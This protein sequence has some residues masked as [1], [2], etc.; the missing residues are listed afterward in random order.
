MLPIY[1]K[2]LHFKQHC[3]NGMVHLYDVFTF[4]NDISSE[5][6]DATKEVLKFFLM[7]VDRVDLV[8]DKATLSNALSDEKPTANFDSYQC[9]QPSFSGG[10]VSPSEGHGGLN[11]LGGL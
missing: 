7:F 4:I 11:E 2:H 10:E 1:F 9:V 8:G 5:S 3:Q 6:M